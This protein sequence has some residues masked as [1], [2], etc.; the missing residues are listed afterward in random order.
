MSDAFSESERQTKSSA[1]TLTNQGIDPVHFLLG[2]MCTELA[3]SAF[4]AT[5][6]D[7]SKE[8]Q[9]R[10]FEHCC[11]PAFD[12]KQVIVEE[13]G[14]DITIK[15]EAATVIIENKIRRNSLEEGAEQLLRYYKKLKQKIL[16]NSKLHSV[17]LSPKKKWGKK[18]VDNIPKVKDE[19]KISIAWKD[20]S[21]LAY[22]LSDIDNL[23]AEKGLEYISKSIKNKKIRKEYKDEEELT[24][25]IL[26]ETETLLEALSPNRKYSV[27]G[28]SL[29]NYGALSR[30]IEV[31][32]MEAIGD[33][34]HFEQTVEFRFSPSGTKGTN[35]GTKE[36][37]QAVNKWILKL[38]SM[39][40]W[41]GFKLQSGKNKLF[42]K[43]ETFQGNIS[44]IATQ[45]AERYN[46]LL[47]EIDSDI[48][49]TNS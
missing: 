46:Q 22:G 39:E 30:R 16:P 26:F 43:S 40:E 34:E 17:F 4:L 2:G 29:W 38:R 3:T 28:L 45:L 23:F 35:K 10:F 15:G 6:I 24:R 5:L 19:T 13:K 9:S 37:R 12:V 25:D 47:A 49:D 1:N 11:I 14:I 8:F 48:K 32:G 41:R 27:E 42:V 44:Q 33:E 36:E 20:L 7:Q 21:P 18:E 31:D